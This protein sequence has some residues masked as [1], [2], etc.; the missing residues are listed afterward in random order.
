MAEEWLAVRID[1]RLSPSRSVAEHFTWEC[2]VV[3]VG[4][5]THSAKVPDDELGEPRLCITD[6]I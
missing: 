2:F 3:R 4:H 5:S 1:G 6:L